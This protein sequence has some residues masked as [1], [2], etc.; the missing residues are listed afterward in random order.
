MPRQVMHRVVPA[1]ELCNPGWIGEAGGGNANGV[2]MPSVYTLDVPSRLR[3]PAELEPF[4][5]D[6]PQR[7]M[8]PVGHASR[9]GVMIEPLRAP[10]PLHLGEVEIVADDWCFPR[11]DDTLRALVVGDRRHS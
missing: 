10:V 4:V 3:P 6:E 5:D 7:L 1:V 2:M 8:Q 9:Q 11:C